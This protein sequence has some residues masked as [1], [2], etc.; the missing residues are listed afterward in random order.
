MKILASSSMKRGQPNRPWGKKLSRKV[1]IANYVF[2]GLHTVRCGGQVR[3]TSLLMWKATGE[4]PYF[5]PQW[6]KYRG[7]RTDVGSGD[8]KTSQTRRNDVFV[9]LV[10][11]HGVMTPSWRFTTCKLAA[12]SWGI[13]KKVRYC[14]APPTVQRGGLSCVSLKAPADTLDEMLDEEDSDLQRYMY[15]HIGYT[16]EKTYV[17]KLTLYS[18]LII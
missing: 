7:D 9:V 12:T 11:L 5:V 4:F 17:R 8:A 13:R 18:F 3:Y 16:A 6:R 15:K 10:V 1:L 2:V 14:G